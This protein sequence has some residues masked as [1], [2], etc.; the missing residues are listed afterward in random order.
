VVAAAAR[1]A[2]P[3]AD[4]A[5]SLDSICAAYGET[6]VLFDLDLDVRRGKLTALV[7]ANGAGKSTLCKVLAGLMEPTAGTITLEGKDI[8]KMPVHRRAK[9][10]LLAPESRG[11]FPGL[12]VE[13]NLMMLLPS[14]DERDQ[15]YARFPVLGS[16]RHIPAGSLSGGEQQMLTMAPVMV[17]P[18][19]LLI[20]DEPTLGLAPLIVEQIMG[21]FAELRDQGVTL[22]V[23]EERAKAVLDIADDVALLELGRLV[24]DGPRADLDPAHLTAIYLGQSTV[25][26]APTPA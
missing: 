15:A 1:P 9:S 8:T 14:A 4:A 25:E 11:I 3:R 6:Q 22:F 13:D 26:E 19:S 12:S 17:K 10:M 24:W 21:V 5:L 2:R 7:G 18:P 20:A 23:V 16:R